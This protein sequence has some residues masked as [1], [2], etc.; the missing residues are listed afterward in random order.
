MQPAIRNIVIGLASIL[1]VTGSGHAQS[2]DGRWEGT[3][4][5]GAH[6]YKPLPPFS[7]QIPF[8]V[9]GGSISARRDYHIANQGGVA[10]T[11]IF[12]GTRDRDGHV[13]IDVMARKEDNTENFH[14]ALLGNLTSQTDWN[15]ADRIDALARRA[16]QSE[17]VN[18]PYVRV[19]HR[20]LLQGLVQPEERQGPGNP[21]G[22]NQG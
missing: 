15:G 17:I 19:L 18:S 4:S 11:A 5:C 20:R 3:Y 6:R 22:G 9:R 1:C 2:F 16:S 12:S 8:D 13:R 21:K 14:L 7:W 10:A